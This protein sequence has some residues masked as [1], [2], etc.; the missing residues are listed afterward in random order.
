MVGQADPAGRADLQGGLFLK[1]LVFLTVA[2]AAGAL[3]WMLFLPALFVA[4][5]HE[6]T[7]FDVTL[8]SLAV[9]PFSGTVQIRGLVLANP[10]G[11][12]VRDFLQLREFGAE[13]ELTSLLSDRPVFTSM[14]LDVPKVTVVKDAQGRTNTEVFHRGFGAVPSSVR[15]M[16]RFLIR[17]LT[18]RFDRFVVVDHSDLEPQVRELKVGLDRVF[19]NVTDLQPLLAPEVW[20][21]LAPIGAAVGSLIPNDLG[22][23]LGEAASEATRVGAARL[24]QAGEKSGDKLQGFFESLEESKKP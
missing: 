24:K 5:L 21:K 9:N 10:T 22:R 14:V 2:L 3:A 11:F 12:P 16:P 6:R 4:R 17:R 8:G 15:P 19:A 23:A 13:A 18:L 20:Q 1:L 7:G